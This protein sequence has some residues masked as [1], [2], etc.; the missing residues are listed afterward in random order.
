MTSTPQLVENAPTNAPAATPTPQGF[1]PTPLPPD[2]V[3]QGFLTPLPPPPQVVFNSGNINT[4]NFQVGPGQPFTFNGATVTGGVVR[5]ASNPRF[6]GS[7][8]Y[9]DT[10]GNIRFAPPGGGEEIMGDSPFHQGYET[11]S[12]A[13]NKNFVSDLGWAPNGQWFYF[14]VSPPPGTD[15]NDPG[16]WFWQPEVTGSGRTFLLLRDCYRGLGGCGLFN[17][18]PWGEWRSIKAQFSP[19]SAYLL[20]TLELLSEGRQAIAVVPVIQDPNFARNL[21]NIVRYDS[22]RWLSDGRLLVSGRRPSDGRVVIA[23]TD[24]GFSY[25]EIIFDATGANLW[26]QDAV[27]RGDG[28]IVALGREC[29][30][31]GALRLYQISNGAATPLSDEIGG[32]TPSRIDWSAGNGEV[33]VTVGGAQ[34]RVNATSGSI[35]L[36]REVLGTSDSGAP[37]LPDY[38]TTVIDGSRYTA[39]QQVQYIGTGNRNLRALPTTNSAVV[40]FVAPNEFVGI[41]AGPWQAE[42]YEWWYISNARSVRGWMASSSDGVSLLSP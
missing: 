2:I 32:G 18:Q 8:A 27:Q 41:I 1:T 20:V 13:A 10:L 7:F 24:V 15:S 37:V 34:Y 29:C 31:G 6:E 12:A 42:G 40:D 33:T 3:Q 39:G 35:R 17:T 28:T 38:P 21:P 22:G 36:F 19:N 4:F 9:T 23:I 14:I 25:E 5:F 26:V 11:S 30:P 16:V